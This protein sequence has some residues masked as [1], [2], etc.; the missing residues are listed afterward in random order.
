MDKKSFLIGF[1]AIY[2]I[3]LCL[4]AVFCYINP[5]FCNI[6]SASAADIYDALTPGVIKLYEREISA[7]PILSR[8]SER[9][10]EAIANSLSVS[11]GKAK[12]LIILQDFAARNGQEVGLE[13]LAEMSDIKLLKFAK[14]VADK[15]V[16][17]IGEKRK[18]ELKAMLLDEL[19]MSDGI[20][21]YFI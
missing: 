2:C 3:M 21:K 20:L 14:G 15:Y 13:K 9:S 1:S 10:V 18:E 11:V 12:A 16:A 6:N 17:K 8:M 19:K 4:T 7:E 5:V